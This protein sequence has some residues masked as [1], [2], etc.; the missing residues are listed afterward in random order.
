MLPDAKETPLL[1]TIAGS[2]LTLVIF[3]ADLMIPLGVAGGVPYMAVVLLGLMVPG[4]RF[5]IL[6][7]I[8]CSTLTL[9]GFF[10]SPSPG[11]SEIWK[12]L[13][14]RSLALFV[15]WSAAI[16][17]LYYKKIELRLSENLKFTH[18]L[19]NVAIASNEARTYETKPLNEALQDCISFI[20]EATGWPI[21]HLYIAEKDSNYLVPS[22]L[23]YFE[24]PKKFKLFKEVTEKTKLELGIGLPGR[25]WES[26]K[27]AWILDVTKDS[28]FP[29]A[30]LAVD[31][32][33]RGAFAFPVI[34]GKEVKAVMEFFSS[35]A[36]EP[37]PLLLEIMASIGAQ[38]GRVFERKRLEEELSIK[39]KAIE[40]SSTTI[41]ITD[42]EGNIEYANSSFFDLVGY[43]ATECIGENMN[44]VRS[45]KHSKEFVAEFWNTI[46]SG[47]MWKGEWCNKKKNGDLFWVEAM[48]SPVFDA[49]GNITHFIEVKEDI[50]ER[51]EVDKELS[52]YRDHLEELVEA[53]SE[54]LEQSLLRSKSYFDMPL[55]GLL[56]SSPD[57]KLIEANDRLCELLGYPR[58]ELLKMTWVDITHPDNREE[59]LN[60]HAMMYSREID[61]YQIEKRYVRKD[62]KTIDCEVSVGC[63][64]KDDGSPDYFVAMVQDISERKK[65]E[66]ERERLNKM[67]TDFLTTAAHELRTPL[68]TIRGYSELMRDKSGLSEEIIKRFSASINKESVHLASLIDD[69]LDISKIEA[70]KSFSLSVKLASLDDCVN[71]SIDLFIHQDTGHKFPVE[72]LGK[73]YEMLIDPG[74]VQQILRNL[75]SNSVKYAEP[76]CEIS[77]KIEYKDEVALVFVSDKS[78]GM[79]SEQ[80]EHIFDKFYRTEEVKNIQGTG[81]GMGIVE[82]LVK[83]HA[84]RIWVESEIDK[85]TTVSFELPKYSPVWRDEFSVKISSID[86]QHK[87]LFNLI[88]KLAKATRGNEESELVNLVLTELVRYAEFHF[89]YEED[90]FQ[91]YNYPEAENHTKIHSYFKDSVENFKKVAESE[92]QHLPTKIINFL[93]KWLTVHIL[94]EDMAYSSF[95]VQKMLKS[96][97]EDL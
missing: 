8:T 20:C 70:G 46:N 60:F 59:N 73:S 47:K 11:S 43:A 96:K 25:V 17:S 22:S 19:K 3:V 10:L 63:V 37:K 52:K 39:S 92:R 36:E 81:L 49:N 69:L 83:S 28:N 53:K 84:G 77:T 23:W 13:A 64:R 35:Q 48:T 78:K 1:I 14:N 9:A 38:M 55:V 15:I 80:V 86:D 4:K 31:I 89:K 42:V 91:K 16:L 62:G 82:H 21:G 54:N 51:K 61:K 29:R 30:E 56:V 93:Y 90:L 71:E 76:G 95:I 57:K 27:P 68:T 34:I 97:D 45:G 6:A 87:E 88:G 58:E 85:G 74:R 2:V 94:K 75:Y 5:I 41:V 65:F 67:K 40:Q 24:N 33:V 66:V 79:T 18:L 44:L 26:G 7:A 72:T 12:V 32:D 50:T